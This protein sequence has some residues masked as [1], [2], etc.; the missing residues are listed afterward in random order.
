MLS[1]LYFW[2]A[3]RL[4]VSPCDTHALRGELPHRRAVVVVFPPTRVANR[5]EISRRSA[6]RE[7]NRL[8]FYEKY[9]LAGVFGRSSN[10]VRRKRVTPPQQRNATTPI[11]NAKKA[12]E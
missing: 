9:K 11:R 7:G 6:T 12:W 4:V 3:K 5:V 2:L 8:R 10:V 1:I